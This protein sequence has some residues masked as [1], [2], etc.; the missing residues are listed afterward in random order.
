MVGLGK[1]GAE[2]NSLKTMNGY[3]H[4]W[5]AAAGVLEEG[6]DTSDTKC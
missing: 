6:H 5:P 2:A 1:G 4:H 3:L